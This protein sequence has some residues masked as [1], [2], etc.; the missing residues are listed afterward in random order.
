[1]P[2]REKDRGP[3]DQARLAGEKA[4]NL[5]ET[6]Q[7][8][9]SEAVLSTLNAALGGGLDQATALKIAAALP[10]GMGGA[11]CACGALSGGVLALGLFL[12]RTEP[13][14]ADRHGAR[15]AAREYHDLFRARFGSTCCRVLS[16]KV[17]GDQAAHHRQCTEL[18]AAAAE[19]A[20]ELILARRPELAGGVAR[21][22]LE[23]RDSRLAGLLKRFRARLKGW[24]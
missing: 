10:V 16:K 3:E 14:A 21:G 1:M 19:L 12:G 18:T 22:Y 5:F 17:K 13:G 7:M 24:F 11:G 9:C 15:E 8:L 4:G 20:M 6:R 23:R 2:G